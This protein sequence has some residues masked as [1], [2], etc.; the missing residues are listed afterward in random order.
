[1]QPENHGLDQMLFAY[2]CQTV[3]ESPFYQL[4]G[5]KLVSLGNGWAELA[6]NPEN[7]HTNALGLVHGGLIMSLLDAAMGNAVRTTG[8]KGITAQCQTSFFSPARLQT[9]LR[10]KGEVVK[11]GGRLVF[12]KANAFCGDEE[13]AQGS[14]TFYIVGK[15]D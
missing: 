1:M 9:D 3:E 8:V 11:K 2:L 12:T 5:I 6:V 14:A 4:M 7:Q 15:V 13:I 10:A